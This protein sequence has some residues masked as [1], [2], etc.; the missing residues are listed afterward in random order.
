MTP[1]WLAPWSWQIFDESKIQ[2]QRNPPGRSSCYKQPC[3]SLP[4]DI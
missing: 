4:T 1:V 3:Y 2:V